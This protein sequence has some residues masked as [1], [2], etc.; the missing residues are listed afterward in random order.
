MVI[1]CDL[2]IIWMYDSLLGFSKFYMNALSYVKLSVYDELVEL[3][4]N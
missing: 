2:Y 1:A 4:D 3:G